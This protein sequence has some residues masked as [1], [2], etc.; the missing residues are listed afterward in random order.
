ME[1][2]ER[3]LTCDAGIYHNKY[4]AF[5]GTSPQY[6]YIG[7]DIPDLLFYGNGGFEGINYDNITTISIGQYVTGVNITNVNLWDSL[8]TLY[9]LSNNPP[10][11]SFGTKTYA[12]AKLYVPSGTKERYVTANGW[13][14]FFPIEE[15]DIDMMWHGE[16]EP[17]AE[18]DDKQKCEKPSINY[19]NGKLTFNSSTEGAICYSTITDDDIKSFNGNE[20]QLGVTYNISVYATKEGY[21]DS[22]KAIRYFPFRAIKGDINDDGQLTISDVVNIVNAILGNSF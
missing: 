19:K 14:N 2:C 7:R 22:E 11:V 10:A 17:N 5:W 16:G 21:L 3:G 12:N 6:L 9:C 4:D 13:N 1:D 15:M 20:V 18:N 8:K